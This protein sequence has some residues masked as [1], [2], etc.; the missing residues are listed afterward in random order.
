MRGGLLAAAGLG[1]LLVGSGAQADTLRDALNRVY[2]A[3]P[4]LTGQRAQLR[5]LDEGVAIARALSRPQLS[6]TAG[7]NQDLTRTGG[8]NG[9]NLNV[10]VDVS[11]PLF[12]GGS[13][14][15]QIRA[16][17]S[18]CSPAAPCLRAVEGDIFTEAFAAYMDVIRTVDRRA[19]PHQVRVLETNLQASRDRF[20]VGDLHPHGCAQSEARSSS[21]AARSA[22]RA[23]PA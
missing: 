5:G 3:N 16:P 9:R 14:R 23:G 21:P 13:V 2:A 22:T 12:N 1:A 11:Y 19:Q 10:G 17:T 20:E 15:N 8:G 6:A 7:V 18:A 4:T